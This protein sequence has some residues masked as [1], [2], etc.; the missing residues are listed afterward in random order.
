MLNATAAHF[1]RCSS[2]W[3][4]NT[5]RRCCPSHQNTLRM[6]QAVSSVIA[7]TL[8][9][10][11]V[12]V[13][14]GVEGLPKVSLAVLSESLRAVLLCLHARQEKVLVNGEEVSCI[15]GKKTWIVGVRRVGDHHRSELYVATR[16][17]QALSGAQPR[18]TL[19]AHFS[20]IVP[21]LSIGLATFQPPAHRFSRGFVL[22][23]Y[24]QTFIWRKHVLA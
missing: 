15:R 14:A 10:G 5:R 16:E 22:R 24:D 23:T 11:G 1:G 20:C 4:L 8:M 19:P 7:S 18:R 6:H 3:C 17:R 2:M 21:A 12:T 13:F 9:A